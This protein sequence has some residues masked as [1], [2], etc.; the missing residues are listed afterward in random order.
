MRC[1][2]NF[3]IPQRSVTLTQKWKN[4]RVFLLPNAFNFLEPCPSRSTRARLCPSGG[5]PDEI[6]RNP[7]CSAVD[8]CADF[9]SSNTTLGGCLPSL[10]QTMLRVDS[11]LQSRVGRTRRQPHTRTL[12]RIFPP[13]RRRRRAAA[14]EEKLIARSSRPLVCGTSV[15]QVRCSVLA[16]TNKFIN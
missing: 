15:W 14:A 3:S 1:T 16:K 8:V 4:H 5:R 12:K 9:R 11:R 7:R 10:C 2:L 6:T 13:E